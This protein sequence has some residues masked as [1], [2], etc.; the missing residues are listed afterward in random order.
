MAQNKPYTGSKPSS[1]QQSLDSPLVS[2]QTGIY[3]AVVKEIDKISR[4][5][6]LRVYL[7]TNSALDPN[8]RNNWVTVD[9]ASP[10]MGQTTGKSPISKENTYNI[11]RQ[12]YGFFMSPPD[13]GN[14]VLVC[15]PDGSLSNGYWFAC[16]S[17]FLNRSQVPSYGAVP[18][19]LI[20][21]DT[22]PADLK[23]ALKSDRQYPA[24]EFNDN[25][26][27]K[28]KNLN[29]HQFT[30]RPINPTLT[31]QF[32]NQGLDGD[33][34]RGPLN[35][36]SNRDPVSSVFGFSTPGRAKDP[37]A[38]YTDETVASIK[39]KKAELEAKLKSGDFNPDDFIVRVRESGH[40]FIMDDGDTFGLNRFVR[41][42]TA[43]GHQIVMND[44]EE[45]QCVY[46]SSANG[47]TWVELTPSGEVLIYG[48]RGINLRSH[49]PIQMHS[50]TGIKMNAPTIEMFGKKLVKFESEQKIQALS[51]DALN[52]QAKNSL[53]ALSNSILTLQGQNSTI[54]GSGELVVLGGVVK[55]NSGGGSVAPVVQPIKKN[56]IPE[57]EPDGNGVWESKPAMVPTIVTH[58]PTHEPFK[59]LDADEIVS[60]W[61]ASGQAA[62]DPNEKNTINGK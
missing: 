53:T 16:V 15:F 2:K 51:L 48:R 58:A 28:M 22:V 27:E 20:D 46:I 59:R 25:D 33:I 21:M 60:L 62:K 3:R 57:S 8:D 50:D 7:E 61:G 30:K 13:I 17:P 14:V 37:E 56:Q 49:G 11:S 34:Y 18:H 24:G 38:T 41:L 10:Y 1:L 29:W 54:K 32:I 31:K 45:N 5:G 26:P 43:A 47:Q 19:N 36:S 40:S 39:S 12:S 55:I 35:S 42:R 6:R 9:Y 4:N 23:P 52:L 44:S